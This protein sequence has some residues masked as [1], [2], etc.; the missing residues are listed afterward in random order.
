MSSGGTTT[1][2]TRRELAA[3][4]A[5]I[6]KAALIRNAVLRRALAIAACEFPDMADSVNGHAVT[7]DDGIGLMVCW[8]MRACEELGLKEGS[9]G[10]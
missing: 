6:R 7:G 2:Q 10:V 8:V 4:E 9:V 5:V 3:D 1:E